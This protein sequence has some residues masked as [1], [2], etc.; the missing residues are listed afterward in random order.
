M[1][2]LVGKGL[3]VA[4]VHYWLVGMR[5]GEKV[6]E[7]LCRMFPEAVIFT[8]VHVPGSVSPAIEA[9]E[10][11]TSFVD[12]LP[13]SGRLYQSYLPLMPL[14]LE[15]LDL[16]EFDLVISSESGPAK[17]VLVRPD[18]LHVC[19]CHSPMR[20]LW[21]MYPDYREAAGWLTRKVMPLLTHRLRMWDALSALRVDHFVANSNFIAKRIRRAYRR[22]AT[23][24]HPPVD[25]DRFSASSE[26][27]DYYLVFGQLVRYKRADIAVEAFGRLGRRLIV[28]GDGELATELKRRAASNIEFLGRQPDAVVSR[29]LQRCRAL[30]FPGQEDFGIVPLEAM[31]SGR[32]VIAFGR[33]GALDYVVPGVTGRF[34]REQTAEALADAVTAFET[35]IGRFDPAAIRRHAES[36]SAQAFRMRMNEFLARLLKERGLA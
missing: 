28:I 4:I 18:A 35:E 12:R 19:Y 23:V 34:F 13:F 33:G 3:R 21:D 11:R 1:T 31:A 8:H 6:L 17:G 36:F 14:A 5:G 30:V 2:E 24:I 25:V 20:Y 7:E 16:R 26:V 32:P 10:I 15:Q 27:E 9:H 22:D 29:Y